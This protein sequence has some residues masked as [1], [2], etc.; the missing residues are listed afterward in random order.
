M[1]LSLFACQNDCFI[2]V[3]V[4]L[5]NSAL[6]TLLLYKDLEKG[7]DMRVTMKFYFII[8]ARVCIR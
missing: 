6:I 5:Y 2:N 1:N 3:V 7:K 8:Y 4:R